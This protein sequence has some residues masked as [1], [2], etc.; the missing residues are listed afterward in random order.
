MKAAFQDRF[1]SP[2]V[3]STR[4]VDAP[5]AA[6]NEV[7]VRVHCSSVTQGDR[8]LRAADFPGIS[9]VAGRLMFGVLRPRN[10]TGGTNFAGTIVAVGRD[11]TRFSVG[12]SVFG[13]CEHSAHAEF[14]TLGENAFLSKI[15]AGVSHEEAAAAPY[16][17][18]SAL[19]F[20]R[21][22][23][24]LKV[25][26]KLLIVGAAGGV[27]RYAIQ[28][29]RH[30]GA[31]VT[32]VCSRN[33]FALVRQLGAEAAID[34]GVEDYTRSNERFDV[35]LDTHSGAGFRRAKPVLAAGG[36]Y[37]TLYLNLLVLLQIL[38]TSWGK[39][40]KVRSGLA[41]GS[42]QHMDDVA[43]LLAATALRPVVSQRYSLSEI[44]A[45]HEALEADSSSG[46]I[47]LSIQPVVRAA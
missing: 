5:V 46:D 16:G 2:Q 11:V 43:E 31:R 8:R 34:Y 45:A 26:E 40:P 37:V 24:N 10:R 36:R 39:G 21:D 33:Q 20:L 25:G 22:V 35:I 41:L 32:A 38:L 30:L 12:E 4:E 15:P 17:A 14:L 44:G 19:V 23:A 1:G 6:H 29:G 9:A 42:A 47:V 13:T 3:L 27:G 7:L 18:V 28:L